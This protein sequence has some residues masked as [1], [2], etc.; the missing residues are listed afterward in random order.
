MSNRFPVSWLLPIFV[1]FVC[2]QVDTTTGQDVAATGDQMQLVTFSADRFALADHSGIRWRSWEPQLAQVSFNQQSYARSIELNSLNQWQ[3]QST[4][5]LQ[6]T[7]LDGVPMF[8]NQDYSY[9][10]SRFK[11]SPDDAAFAIASPLKRDDDGNIISRSSTIYIC[12]ADDGKLSQSVAIDEPV[13]DFDF[14][15]NRWLVL[16]TTHSVRVYQRNGNTLEFAAQHQMHLSS[17]IEYRSRIAFGGRHVAV[18]QD[19]V[20]EVYSLETGRL[21]NRFRTPNAGAQNPVSQALSADGRYL[22]ACF[23]STRPDSS[24]SLRG[25]EQFHLAVWDLA[26][27]KIILD[28]HGGYFDNGRVHARPEKPDGVLFWEVCFAPDSASV[29]A[30]GFYTG[31]CVQIDIASGEILQN[32]SPWDRSRLGEFSSEQEFTGAPG[33]F[34]RPAAVRP[35][36]NPKKL[37]KFSENGRSSVYFATDVWDGQLNLIVDGRESFSRFWLVKP[38]QN[39]LLIGADLPEP[40]TL[41]AASPHL[42]LFASNRRKQFYKLNLRSIQDTYQTMNHIV[43]TH[44]RHS[45]TCLSV[46]FENGQPQISG[47]GRVDGI[48]FR[49]ADGA[50]LR[51]D[52]TSNDR[53]F[54]VHDHP[55]WLTHNAETR[56]VA[57]RSL[58]LP[59]AA[60]FPSPIR[61]ETI[62]IS[63]SGT[64]WLLLTAILLEVSNARQASC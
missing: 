14:A 27:K 42:L 44:D 2:L 62:G 8:L 25:S 35:G 16:V 38:G 24:G 64:I 28:Q 47:I 63:P 34:T 33:D 50:L 36:W 3:T 43:S 31:R 40:V 49:I 11:L 53:A 30:E 22:A 19:S 57:V 12:S 15:G 6:A 4:P 46:V 51:T 17:P 18:R 7:P 58:S 9:Y 56:D 48:E 32:F 60:Q 59:I 10:N 23:S 29:I 39:E 52:A 61:G 26:S 20:L 45:E 37:S 5:A 41:R 21:S 55:W 13:I 54:A 1:A